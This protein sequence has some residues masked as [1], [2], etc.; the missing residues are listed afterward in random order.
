MLHCHVS[1]TPLPTHPP[2]STHPPFTT[3]P[4]RH[5]TKIINKQ[6]KNY[7]FCYVFIM[8]QKGVTCDRVFRESVFEIMS[9]SYPLPYPNNLDCG[10]YILNSTFK[11]VKRLTY[12][13]C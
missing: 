8:P 13:F 9:V 4:G 1:P 5:N 11:E 6:F 7:D 10:A 12:L 2:T 3:P